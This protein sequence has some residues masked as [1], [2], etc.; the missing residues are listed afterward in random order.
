MSVFIASIGY[1]IRKYT[2]EEHSRVL[3]EA[4]AE[5]RKLYR[6]EET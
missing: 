5:D 4:D 3:E 6:E 1:K 2:P